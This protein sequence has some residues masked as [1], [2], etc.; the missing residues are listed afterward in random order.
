MNEFN[1]ICKL[2]EDENLPESIEIL[3]KGSWDHPMYGKLDINDLTFNDLIQNFNNNVRGID[4]S[5][6]LEH[7]ETNHKSE[8]IAWV[9]NLEKKDNKLLAFIDWTKF[10]KE[11]IKDKSFRYFSPEF[12][13][14][15]KDP[16]TGKS[17]NN[18][19]FGG[20]LTNRPF[21][22]KMKPVMLS[23]DI[24]VDNIFI[25]NI[26]NKNEKGDIMNPEILK[27]LKLSENA[28]DEDIIKTL[29]SLIDD[30]VKLTEE[31]ETLTIKL[32]E[33]NESFV[34]L[35]KEKENLNTK[36]SEIT[37]KKSDADKQII[38]L[39]EDVKNINLKLLETEWKNIET[40]GL[41]EGKLLPSMI[42]T[43]KTQYMNNP[44]Q[45]QKII[46][47]LQP[48]IKLDEAGSS[49]GTNETSNIK[50]FDDKVKKI[51]KEDKKDYTEA[52]ILAEKENPDLFKLVDNE[53][54]GIS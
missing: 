19:L 43:F 15:Y 33:L 47:C 35:E 50:L 4:I 21:I 10:G 5:F 37:N 6:D 26:K 54:R 30:S 20:S 46:D 44:E 52:V 39:N 24:F 1:Y 29:K 27:T 38:K 9:K 34:N 22:K 23:E 16:E 45:T 14:I 31:K 8:A 32:K 41:N 40:M 42:D 28:S 17:Y 36:L 13:K 7:G 12:K 53:R 2:N 3:R 48:V 25:E 11:K 51:M 49:K 18:V